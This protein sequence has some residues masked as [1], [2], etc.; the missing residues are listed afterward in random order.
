MAPYGAPPRVPVALSACVSPTHY[1][2]RGPIWAPPKKKVLQYSVSWPHRGSAGGP[3]GAVR[4]RLP[5]PVQ[6][7]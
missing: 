5:H 1:T 7:F 4:M 3:R 2:F 6:R